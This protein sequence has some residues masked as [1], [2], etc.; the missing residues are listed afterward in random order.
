MYTKV[1]WTQYVDRAAS[2]PNVHEGG[3]GRLARPRHPPPPGRQANVTTAKTH[4]PFLL[5]LEAEWVGGA[6]PRF[7]SQGG[8]KGGS[9]R[10][11][12]DEATARC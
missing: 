6:P 3:N 4:R 9:S 8:A 2:F 11:T 12:I 7:R 10:K 5:T 1:D